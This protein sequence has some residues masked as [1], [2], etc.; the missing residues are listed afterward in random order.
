TPRDARS[1]WCFPFCFLSPST[2]KVYAAAIAA[3]H[4]AVDGSSL[5]EHHLI[6]RFLRVARGLNPPCPNFTPSWDLSVVL[7]GL[8]RDPFEQLDSAEIKYL[9]LKTLLL[10]MLTSIKGVGDLHAFSVNKSCLEFG[11]A[12]SHVTLRPQPGYVPRV[13]T[14]PLREQ[15]VNLQALP[16]EKAEPALELLCPVCSLRNYVERNQSFRHSLS[17]LEVSR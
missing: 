15:V 4:D 2:L 1:E 3:Y 7:S 12:D 6:V 13:P 9:S 10:I 8:Q 11:P 16:P 17:A 14:T 5:G